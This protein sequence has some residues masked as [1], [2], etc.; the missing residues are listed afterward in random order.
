MLTGEPASALHELVVR[1]GAT[2]VVAA[3]P[4]QETPFLGLGG[5]VDR[6]AQSLQV[7]LFVA[8]DVPALEAWGR[9]ERPLRVMLGVDRSLP[10]EAA[11]HWVKGLRKLGPV[12]LVAGR[13]FWAQEETM[14]LGL[15][16]PLG[17]G[18]VTPELRQALEKEAAALVEPLAEG[19]K[20]VR[21]RLEVG[22]G[23]IADHLV[24]LAAE[25]KADLLVVGYAPPAGA[26]QALERVATR[27]AA[28]EDVRGVRASAGGDARGGRGAAA[29][30]H[31]A[32]DDGLLQ[33]GR[34][35]HRLRVLS[36]A[37]GGHGAAAARHAAAARR[38]SS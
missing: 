23:R 9:G 10:F 17:F 26:G 1:E 18:D 5:T 30:A 25:E 16:Q 22:M 38:R 12:E 3:A 21:V 19:G 36:G 33:A 29:G 37:F 11:R 6:L 24:S 20:P 4:S 13:I 35:R 34:S 15:E 7:P 32:G 14:R 28:G 8:R 27:D 2:L 31:G